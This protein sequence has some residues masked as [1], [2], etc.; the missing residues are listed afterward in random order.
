MKYSLTM[1]ALMPALTFASVIPSGP[2]VISG[3]I[4]FDA[5]DKIL[6]IRSTDSKNVIAWDD[7]SVSKD[8]SVFFDSNAYLNIV[9]SDKA[10]VIDGVVYGSRGSSIYLFNP[11][12]ITVGKNAQLTGDNIIL[13][14]SRLKEDDINNFIDN[15]ELNF[16]NRGMGKVRL[17]GY[18][19]A[20]NLTVDGSQVIIAK[21]ENI[22]TDTSENDSVKIH[23]SVK[24]ID[25]GGSKMEDVKVKYNLK[26]EDGLVDHTGKTVIADSSDFLKIKNDPKGSYFIANDITLNE[27]TEP[28]TGKVAFQGN[29]DG[30]FNTITYNMNVNG[31]EYQNAG[32]F[33]QLDY[34]NVSN[35]KIKDA[36]LNIANPVNNS[37]I[38]GLSG[39]LHST[40][41]KNVEVHNLN[42]KFDNV[43]GNTLYTGTV[44]GEALSGYQNTTLSNLTGSYSS[45][46]LDRLSR[47][48][49]YNAGSLFGILKGAIKQEGLLILDDLNNADMEIAKVNNNESDLK[50][51]RASEL[52]DEELLLSGF[53]EDHGHL[54][55]KDF[56]CPFFI[57]SDIEAL[58]NEEA[59][60][61]YD[62]S[63]TFKDAFFNT[64]DYVDLS[65]NYPQGPFYRPGVYTHNYKN[66]SD[67]VHF[68]FTDGIQNGSELSFNITVTK[69]IVEIPDE[70]PSESPDNIPSEKPDERPSDILQD[71]ITD[72]PLPQDKPQHNTQD[73]VPD[74]H[75]PDYS[76]NQ[77]PE[78]KPDPLEHNNSSDRYDPYTN[79]HNKEQTDFGYVPYI[80]IPLP[81]TSQIAIDEGSDFKKFEKV[82]YSKDLS[83]LTFATLS[84]KTS[85]ITEQLL[86]S[87]GISNYNDSMYAQSRRKK[88][89]KSS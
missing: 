4:T 54:S 45:Q 48:D 49:N 14:T 25:I 46:T 50:T 59:P 1:L 71:I 41:L 80:Y 27:L 69:P 43:K 78:L 75:V 18:V 86:S 44:S 36:S 11:N 66:K 17:L 47:Y 13:S 23:S 57:S 39:S 20:E 62:F 9:Q 40:V 81:Q 67:K 77:R 35:L 6:G 34:A 73:I 79:Y 63:N 15:G 68:Y 42:L 24:R 2:D 60:E 53:I 30:A 8:A 58:Y 76:L 74:Y 37:H 21:H 65:F 56:Y 84:K 31:S 5:G 19:N 55:N 88:N 7:F 29:I 85:G 51:I 82:T 64:A 28:V 22:R 33:S 26:A 3:H 12:G 87:L 10:S 70:L 61:I 52:K 38:G 89:S 83:K 32:L 72:I 16:E